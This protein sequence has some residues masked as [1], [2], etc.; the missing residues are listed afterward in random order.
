MYSRKLV[1]LDGSPLGDRVLPYVRNLAKKLDAKVEL[2]RV[3][4]PEPEYFYPEPFEFQDRHDASVHR[5]ENVMTAMGTAKTH[6]EAAGVA[7]TAVIHGPECAETPEREKAKDNKS[8]Y[9]YGA[10]A[11]YIVQESE[12][13]PDTLIVMSTHG[14]SGAGRWVMG[15][16]H[17]QGAAC[18]ENTADDHPG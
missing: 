7:A 3:F 16:G 5:R 4:D 14:R 17:R 2:F 1:P 11:E 10:A 12:K 8:D 15:S 18:G 13:D 9:K 6:L